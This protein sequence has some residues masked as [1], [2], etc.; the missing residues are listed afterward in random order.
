MVLCGL[1]ELTD[2]GDTLEAVLERASGMEP[3]RAR[4]VIGC[5]GGRST[6]RDQSGIRLSRT[7]AGTTF[8][9]ADAKSTSDLVIAAVGTDPES[10]ADAVL[11]TTASVDD[12][13]IADCV[14]TA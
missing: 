11:P 14:A 8:L 1:R 3:V 7:G 2:H 9:L 6:V 4:W 13:S 12:G 10:L 5:D